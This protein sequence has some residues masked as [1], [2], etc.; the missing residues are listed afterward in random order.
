MIDYQA[1]L[2]AI[3]ERLL[4]EIQDKDRQIAEMK[5]ELEQKERENHMLRQ[6]GGQEKWEVNLF[7]LTDVSF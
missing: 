7:S 1:D 3:N 2:K 6:K 5:K 4:A